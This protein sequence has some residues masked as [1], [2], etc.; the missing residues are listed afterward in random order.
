MKLLDLL[1]DYL[2]L[3][4]TETEA[5]SLA[6]RLGVRARTVTRD[7]H[8]MLITNDARSDRL[9]FHVKNDIVAIVRVG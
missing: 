9:N 5:F 7:G 6:D 3:G 2:F 4:V 8:G 1:L